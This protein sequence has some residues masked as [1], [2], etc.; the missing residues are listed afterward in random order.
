MKNKVYIIGVAPYGIS[1]LPPKIRRIVRRA[2]IIFGG[3]RLLKQFD[4]ATGEKIVIGHNL[5]EIVDTIRQ[6]QEQRKIVVLASGDPNFYGIASY[7]ITHLGKD[8]IEILPNISSMQMAFALIKES[9]E[10]AVF[11]SVHGRSLETIAEVVRSHHKIGIFTDDVNT[12]SRIAQELL[13]QELSILSYVCQNLGMNDQKML[14]Q[15]IRVSNLDC[16]H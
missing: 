14:K 16:S 5:K 7:I 6:N 11:V 3:Q 4:F 9:W 8:D 15:T 13:K 12:P 1:S 2:G 10:D